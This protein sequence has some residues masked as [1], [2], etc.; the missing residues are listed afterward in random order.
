MGRQVF[1]RA[2][3]CVAS[4][5]LALGLGMS[6]DSVSAKSRSKKAQTETSVRADWAVPPRAATA[7]F[8]TIS[9]VLARRDAGIAP[10]L[11]ETTPPSVR[12]AST[13]NS[14]TV[15][16]APTI[17]QSVIASAHRDPFGLAMFRAP[18]GLLWVKWRAVQAEIERELQTVASCRETLEDCNPAAS[19]FVTLVTEARARE[20]RAQIGYVNRAVNTA[21]RYVSDDAQHGMPDRWSAPLATFR[22]GMGD[23]EDYAIAKYVILRD[24]GVS[25]AD[26]RLLLVRDRA[27]GQ[28]HAVLAV[29]S[30]E[31]WLILD[32]RHH[33]LAEDSDI[34]HFNPL[35]AVDHHGISLFA[36]PYARRDISPVPAGMGPMPAAAARGSD[37]TPAYTATK[38]VV[39]DTTLA[40]PASA[41]PPGLPLLM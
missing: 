11:A 20:G 3:V 39:G 12:L 8:F 10:V 41:H 17:Q 16:D 32:N 7:R 35:F 38:L 28:D 6:A 22:S 31:R 36:A 5:L 4:T 25:S 13:S 37:D 14:R 34:K 23:C 24:A 33:V 40:T 27:V 29:R 18:E 1:E 26:L 19:R 30:E 15:S 2:S 21:V 9:S